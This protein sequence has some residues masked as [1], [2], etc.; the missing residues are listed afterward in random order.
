MP[1]DL[2]LYGHMRVVEYLA[3]MGRLRGITGRAL[4][5]AID[6]AV[7]RLALGSVRGVIIERLSRG[8]RQ[9]VSLAQAVLHKPDLLVL[10]EPSNGLDPRQI[11]EL[12]GLLRHLAQDCAVLVTSH[13]LAEIERTAD[14]AAI[15]LD[16][17]LLTVEQIAHETVAAPAP[18]RPRGAVPGPHASKGD[19]M[20]QV[21]TLVGK[22]VRTLFTSPIAYAVIAVFIV[23]SGYTFTVSLIV[24][25]QATLVHIF[26]QAA[27]QLILLVPL[28]TMRQFAEE[29]RSGTLELLLTAPLR[30]IDIVVAKFI[31]CMVVLAAMTSLTLIYAAVLSAYGDPDWGPIYSGYVGLVMLG[32]ALVAIGLMI[33][34]LTAN[35]IVAA[36]VSLGLF[37][38]L[39]AID[40]LASLLPQPFENWLLGLSLL[41]HFTPFAVGAMYVSDVG[42]FLTVILLGLFLTVRALAR[43]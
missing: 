29:R 24:A 25:K 34:A 22:E 43:R 41:A 8:Y 20:S 13:I 7:E 33:S 12:R 21:A 16:G 40:T 11:I 10:D 32:A 14:R 15:L 18:S 31:A 2:P 3:F 1:E 19:S 23:L 30:E 28:I 5:R 35:Q 9:R 38:L 36:V 37:G 17:R 4:D 42:F 6:A 39:W 27:V 26:F